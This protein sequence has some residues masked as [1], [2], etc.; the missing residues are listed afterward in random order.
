MW[1]WSEAVAGMHEM[2][3]A[4]LYYTFMTATLCTNLNALSNWLDKVAVFVQYLQINKTK[5][6]NIIIKWHK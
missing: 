5:I 1:N 6:Q 2:L 3:N 4:Y